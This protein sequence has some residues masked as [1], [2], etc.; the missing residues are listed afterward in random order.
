[1][2]ATWRAAFER[3]PAESRER[4]LRAL[5]DPERVPIP[6]RECAHCGGEIAPGR[7]R[8]GA[9]ARHCSDRCRKRSYDEKRRLAA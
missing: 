3:Q 9:P 8:R 5:E 6:D 1:M 4:A 2:T 7:G